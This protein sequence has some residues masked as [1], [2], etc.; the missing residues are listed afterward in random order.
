MPTLYC[1]HHV[2][3]GGGVRCIWTHPGI[4]GSRCT[5]MGVTAVRLSLQDNRY[6]TSKLT[7]AHAVAMGVMKQQALWLVHMIVS[8]TRMCSVSYRIRCVPDTNTVQYPQA[9]HYVRICSQSRLGSGFD[10]Q[11]IAPLPV[12]SGRV[13]LAEQANSCFHG[14]GAS[15]ARQPVPR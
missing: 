9:T 11:G 4:S 13:G 2:A 3:A 14:T 8:S 7:V 5:T 10:G 12:L 6:R 15:Q 1:C